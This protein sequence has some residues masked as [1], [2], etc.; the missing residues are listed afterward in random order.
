MSE[1]FI[2]MD[3]P[4]KYTEKEILEMANSQGCSVSEIR[5]MIKQLKADFKRRQKK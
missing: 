4:I 2:D 1:Q 5:N 3:L